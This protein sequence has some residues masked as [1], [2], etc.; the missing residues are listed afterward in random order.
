MV[1]ERHKHRR[2]MWSLS[3]EDWLEKGLAD[4]CLVLRGLYTYEFFF[5]LIPYNLH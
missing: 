4:L 3:L 5:S 2:N 1:L